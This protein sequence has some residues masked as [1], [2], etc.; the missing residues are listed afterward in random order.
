MGRERSWVTW[1]RVGS[2]VF[3]APVH[4]SAEPGNVTTHSRLVREAALKIAFL[5]IITASYIWKTQGSLCQ[6]SC[7]YC[8]SLD[9]QHRNWHIV[10]A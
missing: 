5:I 8:P 4:Q 9:P 2:S 10:G 1:E 6:G 3:K 7:L